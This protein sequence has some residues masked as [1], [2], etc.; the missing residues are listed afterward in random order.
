MDLSE[1][2]DVQRTERQMDS[3]QHLSDTFYEDVAEYIAER[4]AER[5]RLA[6]K[7]DDPFGDPAV[8][9][10]TDEIKTAE[11]VVQAIYDRRI[12]KVVKLASFDAADMKTDTAGLTSEERELFDDLV[13]RIITN[14]E[15]VLSVLG[16][17]G[18]EDSDSDS[19]GEETSSPADE[20]PPQHDTEESIP[21]ESSDNIHNT[22]A[23]NES[24]LQDTDSQP[25]IRD[26]HAD[27]DDGVDASGD[28][29]NVDT[30]SEINA[31][32]E[33]NTSTD[34]SS[35]LGSHPTTGMNAGSETETETE[36]EAHTHTDTDIDTERQH[37]NS[38]DESVPPNP[39]DV[40]AA[41]MGDG[42]DI[43]DAIDPSA[44]NTDIDNVDDNQTDSVTNGETTAQP[45]SKNLNRNDSDVT[46]PG[47]DEDRTQGSALDPLPQTAQ[48]DADLHSNST[49][50]PESDSQSRPNDASIT[51]SAQTTDIT[52]TSDDSLNTQRNT[53]TNKSHKSPREGSETVTETNVESDPEPD[54]K[55]TITPDTPSDDPDRVILRI[56]A[57]VGRI[58]GVDQR[59]Y[60]LAAEDIVMLPETNAEPLLSRDAAT[61]LD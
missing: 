6:S 28:E 23:P 5:R 55:S 32:S 13:A 10:L 17:E 41:A 48:E 12:G 54:S 51:P 31:D 16:G 11:E 27:A 50:E 20:N 3:L 35:T 18:E 2:Q 56:T 9:R 61:R 25:G 43:V 34:P 58:L 21:A 39:D 26:T 46:P 42:G 44:V 57:D 52:H 53:D 30:H 45:D 7:T 59:E 1:L 14:R 8:G 15:H 4:K 24:Q 37:A 19:T 49:V 47:E 60:D 22:S 36:T 38:S 29:T 40:L 33:D